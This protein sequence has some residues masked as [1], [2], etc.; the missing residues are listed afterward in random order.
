[1][2]ILLSLLL[3]FLYT[4]LKFFEFESVSLIMANLYSVFILYFGYKKFRK[5]LH[6]LFILLSIIIFLL[7]R[8]VDHF[9]AVAFLLQLILTGIFIFSGDIQYNKILISILVFALLIYSFVERED[10]F[11]GFYHTP[12]QSLYIV[13]WGIIY[14]SLNSHKN[15]IKFILLLISVYFVLIS[16]SRSG[17]IFTVVL[18]YFTIGLRG[19]VACMLLAVPLLLEMSLRITTVEDESTITRLWI[20]ENLLSELRS[21]ELFGNGIGYTRSFVRELSGNPIM[22]AHN[23][24]LTLLLDTGF[25]GVIIIFKTFMTQAYSIRR[26]LLFML[27]LSGMIHGYLFFPVITLFYVSARNSLVNE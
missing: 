19:L 23:D 27:F 10:R 2:S 16:G 22:H 18:T 15:W 14:L 25:I 7:A 11:A 21:A 6:Y 20:L 3:L 17:L 24:L 1:M 8:T 26:T 5:K 13:Q 4:V 12:N 9:H